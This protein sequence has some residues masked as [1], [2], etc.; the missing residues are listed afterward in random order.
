MMVIKRHDLT[1]DLAAGMPS[2]QE[3]RDKEARVRALMT[4]HKLDALLLRR[5]RDF[6]DV[7]GAVTDIALIFESHQVQQLAFRGF[8]VRS[9]WI[10]IGFDGSDQLTRPFSEK[11]IRC[12][13]CVNAKAIEI[14]RA[15]ISE[16][17]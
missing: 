14:R 15:D 13:K 1:P 9:T 11:R 8:K 12:L 5:V 3:V 16:H 10:R 6:A 7:A 2:L 4:R 17:R